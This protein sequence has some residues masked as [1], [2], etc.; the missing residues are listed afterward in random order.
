[1]SDLDD[2]AADLGLASADGAQQA[3]HDGLRAGLHYASSGERELL[4]TQKLTATDDG[5]LSGT[6]TATQP[7][8]V[9]PRGPQI[10]SSDKIADAM[11][12]EAASAGVRL[13]KG[14]K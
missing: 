14:R 9:S 11:A 13:L 8:G 10:A 2:L 12:N 3:G 6:V 4:G 1:M 5:A 7:A